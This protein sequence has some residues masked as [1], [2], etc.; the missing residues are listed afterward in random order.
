[1]R[2]PSWAQRGFDLTLEWTSRGP[3]CA[4]ALER[5]DVIFGKLNDK[6]QRQWD[7]IIDIN[8]NSKIIKNPGF[9]WVYFYSAI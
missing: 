8:E 7:A 1:M 3:I 2:G 5:T 4:T 6:K 9:P